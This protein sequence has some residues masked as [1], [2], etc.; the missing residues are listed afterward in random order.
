MQPEW[1]VYGFND[2]RIATVVGRLNIKTGGVAEFSDHLGA[3]LTY[4]PHAFT[5]ITRAD[6]EEA[7]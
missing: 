4:A 7:H 2:E 3:F 5:I 1:H 6:W